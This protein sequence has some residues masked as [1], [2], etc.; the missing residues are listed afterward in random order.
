[1]LEPEPAH[2]GAGDGEIFVAQLDPDHAAAGKTSRDGDRR[3]TGAAGEVQ[4]ALGPGRNALDDAP[5]PPA[6][7]AEG[8]DIHH[9]VVGAAGAAEETLDQ[10]KPWVAVRHRRR[11]GTTSR[12]PCIPRSRWLAKS[13]GFFVQTKRYVP[14]AF[15]VN[16][17]VDGSLES[18]V[19]TEI[20]AAGAS[21]VKVW[22]LKPSLRI[23][24]STGE[25]ALTTMRLG[26][27]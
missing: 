19:S 20:P 7:D 13:G 22:G 10:R 1:V 25:P 27:K 9:Q 2:L 5:L 15:G 6:V 12:V 14:G 4:D 8:G 18:V 26:R 24:T 3:D 17:T 21:I 23:V 16:E 11:Q